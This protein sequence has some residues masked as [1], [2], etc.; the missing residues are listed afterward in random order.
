MFMKRFIVCQLFFYCALYTT[1]QI[2]PFHNYT[3]KNGLPATLIFDIEQD[4]L[5]YLWL[6][7]QVGAVK[8]DGYN[9]TSYTVN[10]GLPDN[11]VLDIFIDSKDR[12]WFATESGGLAY[13]KNN[14]I[15]VLIQTAGLVSDDPKVFEDKRGN[16]WYISDI[17]FSVI[18][19]DTILSFNENNSPIISEILY[20]YVAY[21]GT[22]WLTT[23]EG[24][25]YFDIRLHSYDQLELRNLIVR[26]IK[27]DKPGSYWFATQE[28]GVLHIEQNKLLNQFNSSNGLES[29]FSFALQPIGPDEMLVGTSLPGGLH[30]I[31]NDEI[32]TSWTKEIKDFIIWQVLVDRRNRIWLRTHEHGLVLIE[33]EKLQKINEYN[34]LVHNRPTKLFEDSNGNIWIT[35]WNGLSKYGKI[36]FQIFN[37]GFVDDD[38]NIQS[39]ASFENTI[40]AGTYSG[41]NI[42]ENS[43][44][45]RRYNNSN[46]LKGKLLASVPSILPLGEFE[47]WLGTHAGLTQFDGKSFSIYEDEVFNPE[48]DIPGFASDIEKL[49]DELY[50]ATDKGL[51]RYD[52]EKYQLFNMSDGLADDYIWSIE[53]DSKNNVWC[54]TV[55]GLSI[56]DGQFFHNYDTSDGLT[57]N[58]CHD[59]AFDQK[60]FAWLATDKGISRIKLTSDWKIKCRNI[61]MKDGLY[62]ENIFLITVDKEGFVWAGHNNGLDR[63][64]P[65]DFSVK[66]YGPLE[67]FLPVENSLGAVTLTEMNDI[68]FGTAEGVVRYIPQNDIIRTDPP[69]VYITGIGLYN[70]STSILKYATE[71]DSIY[72]LPLNLELKYN[73]NNLVFSYVGLHYTIVEKNRYKYMLEGYD[74]N[75]SEPIKEIQTPPYRKIPPGKY[76]F[77]VVA[78]NCDGI[79]SPEPASFHFEIKPPFYKTWLFYILEILAGIALFIA[80]IRYRERKLRHDREVLAQKVKDRTIEVEKQRDQIAQQKKEITDSIVYAERIQSA[81][82]PNKEYI[83]NLLKDYFILFKPRNI[84][85]G[86]FYWIDGNKSKV[87]VVA[88]DCTGHGVPGAFMSMLGIS[89]LN[90]VANPVKTGE[91]GQILDTLREHLT[92]TLWQTGKD[93]DTRDGMDLSLCIIDFKN[94]NLQFSGAYNPLVIIRKGE[95]V[96][97]KG[98]KMPVGYHGAKISEFVSHDIPL[99]KG[100]CLYMFSDGY[101]DQFGGP[102]DKK[103]KSSNFRELLLNISNLSMNKQK[104][105]LNETIEAWKGINEQVDDILVI[106][107][108]I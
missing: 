36:V 67:G 24:I 101:S 42:I 12:I 74:N 4:H 31:K 80:V 3:V 87:I 100:D 79:W 105:K 38:K 60:G 8:F 39:I 78:S 82:L 26:D 83:D 44:I 98:D 47:I 94:K 13:M 51:I 48:G 28:G 69:K 17:G 10:E 90:E 32:Q 15:N 68:W 61:L 52:R 73:K 23:V 97:Y 88:A 27:E 46:G 93:E 58:Y 14:K 89:I 66:H 77:K 19:P 29:D 86:D 81:V 84:V 1:A 59:I 9:F 2:I 30:L 85:S 91:A 34:N 71:T 62:S 37:E 33:D 92:T 64:N 63:I 20:T 43:E 21:D 6:A 76:T 55:N 65:E 16:I 18:L 35:T 102:D 5:D 11:N 70:D 103:F 108:R 40:Y 95:I 25:F 57:I 75:W 53:I 99:I 41:L 50:C 22:V 96:V 104:V 106:G 7:T 54:A 72:Q 45:I 107:I 49:N 56:F